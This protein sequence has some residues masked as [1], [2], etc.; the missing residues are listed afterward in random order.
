MEYITLN[1]S[2]LKVSRFC[3][4]GCPMGGYGWGNVQESDFIEAIHAAIENGV[5]FFDT[6]DTYG[7]GQSEITLAKGI[8]ENRHSVI[9]ASKFG[10]HVT[11]KG[12]IYDNRP[13]YIRESLNNSLKRLNTDYLDLYIIHYRD[14][15]TPIEDVVGELIRLRDEGKLRY[16]GLSN[17]K[18]DDISEIQPYKNF[19]VSCQN[20]FSLATRDYEKDLFNQVKR[21]GVTPTTW[22]SLGQGILTGKYNRDNINFESNDRRSRDI[23]VNFH[24]EK[25]NN[26]LQIVDELRKI[27]SKYG[28]SIPACAI[29]F[30]LDY[31]SD[32]V[33][34]AGVKNPSQLYSNIEAMGWNLEK[35]DLD[36]LN[37]ISNKF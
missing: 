17:I 32:S 36:K 7:L 27:A 30:I 4:G 12:T 11:S 31:I 22:G 19:F 35:E 15:K 33:V 23:Y 3:M 21:L 10:V 24:G 28:K 1:N 13:E 5:N 29:R 25:L 2:D 26:N 8:A 18:T 20:E 6:S 37:N 9:I 34:L 16:F 14:G